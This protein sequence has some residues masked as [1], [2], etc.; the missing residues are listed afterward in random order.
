MALKKYGFVVFSFC[1]F[2]DLVLNMSD[3]KT[4]CEESVKE[5]KIEKD[6]AADIH[7]QKHHEE[8]YV[9]YLE[10]RYGRKRADLFVQR[11][12]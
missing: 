10:K 5:M 9:H 11:S 8:K 6:A 3:E 7:L 12:R 1:Y 4:I 2:I